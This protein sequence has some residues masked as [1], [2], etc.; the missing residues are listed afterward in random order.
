M[1]KANTLC[2][3]VLG[4][5]IKCGIYKIT[6][7]NTKLAYIGQSKDIKERWRDHM[8]HGLGI[9]TPAGNKLYE[10]MK[11]EG[12]E[13][14]T[15]EILEEC[16]SDQLDEKEKFYIDLYQTYDFGYNATKGN[17]KNK[18]IDNK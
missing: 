13:C 9:D 14:F 15:F 11:K 8:K 17:G 4:I 7:L 3:N 12:L 1:K 2:S 6:N 18:Y 5:G 16:S 10:A